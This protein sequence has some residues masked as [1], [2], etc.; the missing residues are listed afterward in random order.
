LLILPLYGTVPFFDDGVVFVAVL[1]YRPCSPPSPSWGCRPVALPLLGVVHSRGHAG[2]VVQIVGQVD[3][4]FIIRG[5]MGI[6]DRLYLLP[7]LHCV[8]F[9]PIFALL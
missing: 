4:L 7:K 9:P 1:L 2:V 3:D 5:L 8:A 6:R